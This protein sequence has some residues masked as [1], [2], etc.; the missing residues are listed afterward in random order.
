[1]LAGIGT[2]SIQRIS[3]IGG[4]V[5]NEVILEHGRGA[6]GTPVTVRNV[7]VDL[8]PLKTD[9][10]VITCHDR[11][12][13]LTSAVKRLHDAVVKLVMIH[14][15]SMNT[16]HSCDRIFAELLNTLSSNFAVKNFNL[17]VKSISVE[18]FTE[19]RLNLLLSERD[20]LFLR[21]SDFLHQLRDGAE[22]NTIFTIFE[23]VENT[24]VLNSNAV[25]FNKLA[26][27]FGDHWSSVVNEVIL[28]HGGEQWCSPCVSSSGV[29][30][31]CLLQCLIGSEP[32]IGVAMVTFDAAIASE[33]EHSGANSTPLVLRKGHGGEGVGVPSGHWSSVAND[34]IIPRRPRSAHTWDGAAAGTPVAVSFFTHTSWRVVISEAGTRVMGVSRVDFQILPHHQGHCGFVTKHKKRPGHHPRSCG[35]T[36]QSI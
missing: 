6:R 33:A 22:A 13:S 8:E 18:V 14:Q 12:Q 28:E 29:H 15:L 25:C 17:T 11:F 20:T 32:V 27:G 2:S 24:K 36:T 19:N 1:M 35:Y 34:Q 16:H 5:V 10:F 30:P 9:Q 4:S 21:F 31:H 26:V 3:G 7:S 23:D